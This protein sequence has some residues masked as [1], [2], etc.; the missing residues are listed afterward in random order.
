MF[1][2]DYIMRMIHEMVRVIL[3]FLFNV[4]GESVEDIKIEDENVEVK[5]NW[6]MD[7]AHKGKINEAE[8]MLYEN[9]D[10]TNKYELQA[11]LMF[12]QYLNTYSADYLEENNFSQEEIKT[13]IKTVLKLFG[14]DGLT[15][16]LNH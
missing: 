13:G 7:L 6:L 3:K 4:D 12:Y 15:E 1:E 5:Y 14:Q 8:N 11:A 10:I 16:M 9:L 2:D